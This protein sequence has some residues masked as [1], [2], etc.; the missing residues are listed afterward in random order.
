MKS[1]WEKRRLLKAI[2]RAR[3]LPCLSMA[4]AQRS[5]R[6]L[7]AHDS[8]LDDVAEVGDYTILN[9]SRLSANRPSPIIE[10]YKTARISPLVLTYYGLGLGN[11]N[12]TVSLHFAE[13]GFKADMP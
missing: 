1:K 7:V 8:F 11:R 5:T 12:Y 6:D 13:I 10:I 4:V 2:Q 9:T 3:G